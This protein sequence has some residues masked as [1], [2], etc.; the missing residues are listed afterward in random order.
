LLDNANKVFE[1]TLGSRPIAE[2]IQPPRTEARSAVNSR[3]NA[4]IRLKILIAT[5][6]PD[7]PRDRLMLE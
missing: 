3:F 6:T 5:I 7:M 2:A 1:T 4:E